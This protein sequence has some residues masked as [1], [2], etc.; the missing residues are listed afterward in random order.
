MPPDLGRCSPW[1]AVIE[2]GVLRGDY[3]PGH[4]PAT[5]IV[6]ARFTAGT[7]ALFFATRRSSPGTGSV[8]TPQLP[9]RARSE[10]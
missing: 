9:L 2:A 6:T 8:L 4:A 7:V 10:P 3:A 1:L 5:G